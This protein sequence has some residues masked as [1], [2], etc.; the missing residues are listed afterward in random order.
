MSPAAQY[1]AFLFQQLFALTCPQRQGQIA[2]T[3]PQSSAQITQTA[4]QFT[5][6][7]LPSWGQ[8]GYQSGIYDRAFLKQAISKKHYGKPVYYVS[9]PLLLPLNSTHPWYMFI[10]VNCQRNP[11]SAPEPHVLILHLLRFIKT[12]KMPKR[13]S[14][15]VSKQATIKTW[16]RGSKQGYGS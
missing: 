11:S 13:I 14:S 2:G 15:E 16:Q 3:F 6:S 5:R 7:F 4:Q 9:I 10:Q 8:G 12:D 1:P